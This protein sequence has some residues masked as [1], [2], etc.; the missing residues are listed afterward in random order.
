VEWLIALLVKP[1]ILFC[2]AAFVLYPARIAFKRWF[3]EG[4][5]KRLLLLRVN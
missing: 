3:P 2:L 4:R 5:I 1:L